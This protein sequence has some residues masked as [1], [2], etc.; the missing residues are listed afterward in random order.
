LSWRSARL[1]P[2]ARSRPAT[3]IGTLRRADPRHL[4]GW[5]YLAALPL[6]LIFRAWLYW[7]LGSSVSWTPQLDLGVISLPFRSDRFRPA[8][9]YSLLGFVRLILICYSWL[10]VLSGINRNAVTVD[11]VLRMIRLHLG[12]VAGWPAAVQFL[13]PLILVSGIWAAFQPLL[14]RFGIVNPPHSNLHLLERCLLIGA[15]VYLSL[16]YLLPTIL[17]CYLISIYVFLGQNAFWEFVDN[18]GR[19]LLAPLRRLPLRS[20]RVDFAPLIGILLIIF[21][22][23]TLPMLLL[24]LLARNAALWPT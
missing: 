12:R 20:R 11:P 21:L 15:S 14:S 10:L 19:N 4:S 2:L 7:Q 23:H 13:I 18:T 24:G 9:S 3:L 5:P 17:L 8:L 16:K 1:D 22:L 6:L